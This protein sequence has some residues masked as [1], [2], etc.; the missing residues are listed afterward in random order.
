MN[1]ELQKQFHKNTMKYF[2]YVT[3][4]IPS[5]ARLKFLKKN[6]YFRA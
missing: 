6:D 2:D 4:L 1:T 5:E 3:E